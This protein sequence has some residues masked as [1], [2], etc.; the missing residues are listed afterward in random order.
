MKKLLF[1]SLLVLAPFATFAAGDLPVVGVPDPVTILGGSAVV[2]QH[3]ASLD[4]NP[5]V[6]AGGVTGN[7][8][9]RIQP[10]AFSVMGPAGP[11]PKRSLVRN[12]PLPE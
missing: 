2:P 10:N 3:A 7:I 9:P 11:Y 5:G 12:Q 4:G 1:A 6:I 8:S